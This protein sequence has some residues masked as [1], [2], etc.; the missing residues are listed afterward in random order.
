[1]SQSQSEISS[2]KNLFNDFLKVF[3]KLD[4][5]NDIAI[6]TEKKPGYVFITS[7]G[8]AMDTLKEFS[9]K[10]NLSIAQ[11]RGIIKLINQ[12]GII[13]LEPTYVINYFNYDINVFMDEFSNLLFSSDVEEIHVIFCEVFDRVPNIYEFLTIDILKKFLDTIEQTEKIYPR[14]AHVFEK[15]KDSVKT[16]LNLIIALERD[17]YNINIYDKDVVKELSKTPDLVA[18][19]T[20]LF[21][22]KNAQTKFGVDTEKWVNFFITF[23]T[24]EYSSTKSKFQKFVDQKQEELIDFIIKER[25]YDLYS[26]ADL[27]QSDIFKTSSNETKIKVLGQ[28]LDFNTS[29]NSF[30]EIKPPYVDFSPSAK[31]IIS[32]INELLTDPTVQQEHPDILNKLQGKFTR[33][34]LL[35]L[36]LEIKELSLT[37]NSSTIYPLLTSSISGKEFLILRN[38][39]EKNRLG[40]IKPR[41]LDSR[42]DF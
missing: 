28:M 2:Q 29:K 31:I 25:F 18:A 35:L 4:E 17:N 16:R 30:F 32:K 23:Q 14:E 6:L 26:C 27:M 38:I 13:Y 5:Q 36:E 19:L 11:V 8:I 15:L 41:D 10:K 20:F 21:L 39:I 24:T 34:N 42:F 3:T 40:D 12:S 1:M 7:E 33:A 37:C 22:E 9:I